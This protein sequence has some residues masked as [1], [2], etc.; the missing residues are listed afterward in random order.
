VL[1]SLVPIETEVQITE[2]KWYIMRILPYRTL[3]N[4]IEGA[5][6]TF[7]DITEIVQHREALRKA[8]DLLRLAVV[9]RDANDA[10]MVHD[11]DGRILAWNPGAVRKYGWS[12]AEALAMNV[13]DI[14]PEKL[15]EEAIAMAQQL[16]RAEI[17]K[18][19]LTERITKEGNVLKVWITSTALINEAGRIYA[20][21][22]TERTKA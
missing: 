21:S 14:I 17:L 16:S 3:E 18:P 5:V 20:V 13:R 8:G 1:D 4:V 2:G 12:E 10:I 19:Y 15:R 9:V 7:V 6:I 22:T 11:L